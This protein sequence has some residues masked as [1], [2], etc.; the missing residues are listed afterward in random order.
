MFNKKYQFVIGSNFG[1][2][3]KGH[4][5]QYIYNEYINSGLTTDDIL[6]VKFNGGQQAGHT[7][8]K[9]GKR[10]ITSHFGGGSLFNGTTYM[11][12]DCTFYP[13]V[14]IDEVKACK[15]LDIN[16]RLILNP[17][18]MITLHE[19][20]EANINDVDNLSHGTVG[21]GF[22]KTIL[23]NQSNYKLTAIDLMTGLAKS[24]IESILR[25]YYN[26]PEEEINLRVLENMV[27]I[28]A[29]LCHL[30][31]F[32]VSQGSLIDYIDNNKI[33]KVI[34]E[35]C[36]G[37]LLDKNIGVFPHVT[38]S[39]IKEYLEEFI[40]SNSKD[41]VEL[42]IVSRT[43]LTRH[44]NGPMI[45]NNCTQF[46][47]SDLT[48]STNPYQGVFRCYNY[49]SKNFLLERIK[50]NLL[51]LSSNFIKSDFTAKKLDKEVSINL[52]LTHMDVVEIDKYILSKRVN[53]FDKVFISSGPDLKD[54]SEYIL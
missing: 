28:M 18:V 3:G 22:G 24:K 49:S 37:L 21:L 11:D 34:F 2:E 15:E 9:E 4:S 27:D 26:I 16:P 53:Y 5:V 54:I 1:D 52:F 20:V 10:L 31:R 13:K 8:Q 45:D 19:D 12:K 33:E 38:N 35:G 51:H 14:F 46:D 6:V 43:F 41:Q 7:I 23:R 36:Q 50:L 39:S 25:N 48:N 30:D 32:S 42:N 44:G 29:C 47:Y 40:K 17:N